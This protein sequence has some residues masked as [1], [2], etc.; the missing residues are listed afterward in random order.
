MSLKLLALTT[1]V[2]IL[3]AVF[4]ALGVSFSIIY[5]LMCFGQLLLIFTVY[6]ILTDKYTTTRT[7]DDFYEDH[8]PEDF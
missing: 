4:S 1:L 8:S 7:F 3:L 6:K 5:Y 2:L